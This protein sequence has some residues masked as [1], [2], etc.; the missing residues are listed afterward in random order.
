MFVQGGRNHYICFLPKTV[1]KAQAS[2]SDFKMPTVHCELSFKKQFL[3]ALNEQEDIAVA[4][5]PY[6][7][8]FL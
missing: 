8:P 4:E 3:E 1:G 2:K 6:H 5:K 7:I